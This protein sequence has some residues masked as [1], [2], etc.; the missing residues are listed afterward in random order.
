MWESFY[1]QEYGLPL[2]D[3][4]I[5]VPCGKCHSCVRSK[6]NGWRLRLIAELKQWSFSVFITLTFDDSMMERFRDDPNKAVRLFLDRMR[7]NVGNGIKHF[8][9]GEYGEKTGRFHYHGILF[10]VPRNFDVNQVEKL[11]KYGFVYLGWCNER[12][13]HYITKYI[14]KVDYNKN[15][16]KANKQDIP[17]IIVSHGIGSSFVDYARNEPMKK[18]LK[19]FLIT[20]KGAKIPLPRYV[21]AKL[22][23]EQDNINMRIFQYLKPFERY[24]NGKKYTES[25]E[26][27]RDLKEFSKAQI[28]RGMSP[29]IEFKPSVNSSLVPIHGNYNYD[30][31][32]TN[33]ECVLTAEGDFSVEN[34]PF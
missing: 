33:Q 1:K 15:H 6:M 32:N 4:Y 24:L 25:C 8:I 20:G 11:W 17:R 27:Y 12:T 7:K 10:G 3:L 31:F 21:K 5:E 28:S 30:P 22:Y 26:Y 9:I 23:S 34:V 19:P 29:P 2:P 18:D 14:T 13:I 16:K